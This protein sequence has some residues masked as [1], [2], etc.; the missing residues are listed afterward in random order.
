MRAT[1]ACFIV[2]RMG[3]NRILLASAVI[4]FACS[5]KRGPE[6]LTGDYYIKMIDLKV[7]DVP[8][9]TLQVW[10]SDTRSPE[11][12][13]AIWTWVDFLKAKELLRKPHVRV[14]QDDG[15]IKTL[16]LN[17]DD[18]TKITSSDAGLIGT[19]LKVHI[20]AKVREIKYDSITSVY[21][22]LEA[23]QATKMSGKTYWEK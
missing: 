13:H 17:R 21:E 16:F 7:F 8:D 14:R 22:A 15:S 12:D 10:R 23:V 19:D 9:S 5:G 18:Y 20:E 1:L 6:V 2:F 11:R 4:F 3:T